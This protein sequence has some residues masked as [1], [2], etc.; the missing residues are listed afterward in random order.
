G[1]GLYIGAHA[2]YMSGSARAA[3]YQLVY[4][5]INP[6]PPGDKVLG[7]FTGK[8]AGLQAGFNYQ[9][10]NNLVVGLEGDFAWTDAGYDTNTYLERRELAGFT[11]DVNWMAMARARVGVAV[12]RLFVYGAAGVAAADVDA[13]EFL[14]LKS[15]TGE[16]T[17]NT[18]YRDNQT[19]TG[20]TV[21]AGVEYALNR[22]WTLKGEYNFI[23]LDRG[24]FTSESETSGLAT[25]R[26]W[27]GDLDIDQVRVGVN[28][29]C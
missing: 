8:S 16:V 20:W 11:A 22:N 9:F 7:D 14:I 12:D 18:H 13:S 1:K 19:M 3:A 5:G 15:R 21:G 26:S 10:A 6:Q 27:R 2:G 4:S 29:K 17:S 23:N 28:Y 24:T 25:T